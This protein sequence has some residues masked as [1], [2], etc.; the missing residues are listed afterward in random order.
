MGIFV[1]S[2]RTQ[3]RRF[4]YEPRYYDPFK[5]ESVK[6]RMRVRSRARK[7]RGPAVAVYLALL[8]ILALYIYTKM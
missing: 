7:S 6:R 5:D 8:L 2:K 1:P 3:N 4:S